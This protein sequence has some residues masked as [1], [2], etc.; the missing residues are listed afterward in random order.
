[1][2]FFKLTR[3]AS[4]ISFDGATVRYIK[5]VQQAGKIVIARFIEDASPNLSTFVSQHNL[6]NEI[7]SM[8][9]PEEESFFKFLEKDDGVNE[10][11]ETLLSEH[12]PKG[13]DAETVSMECLPLDK[14][15][16]LLLHFDHNEATDKLKQVSH[17][18][19][20][21]P[22]RIGGGICEMGIAL[23]NFIEKDYTGTVLLMEPKLCH[24]IIF[25]QGAFSDCETLHAGQIHFQEN[26]IYF[27]NEVSRF[28]IYYWET[29]QIK[30]GFNDIHL[31]ESN[32]SLEEFFKTQG[33]SI[34]SLNTPLT[35]SNS[36][37]YALAYNSLTL[38]MAAIN[39]NSVMEPRLK[40][41]LLFQKAEAILLRLVFPI[42][43]LSLVLFLFI[44]LSL[45]GVKHLGEKR[46][47]L[48]G[49]EIEQTLALRE[50]NKSLLETI[51]EA[52]TLVQGRN[53]E[54][55][56]FQILSRAMPTDVWLTSMQYDRETGQ[57][58][59]LGGVS[60][61]ETAIQ[62]LYTN[63]EKDGHFKNV[64][65]LFTERMDKAEIARKSSRS[66]GQSI[67][68]FSIEMDAP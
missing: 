36:Q 67:V 20:L 45:Y 30:S 2:R 39:H 43:G 51:H 23:Q 56:I 65:L 47:K 26:P 32:P 33:Y 53:L 59:V 7:V 41:G 10:S 9:A 48:K 4:A 22:D 16:G 42:V 21:I 8:S 31:L 25:S 66:L 60:G 63:L 40:N 29:K 34:S 64:R 46:L 52:R 38:G 49:G 54:S 27:L 18:S 44:M 1:M 17:N 55:G 35:N 68:R 58:I 11:S 13:V 12:L 15:K 24:A 3:Q 62:T 28:L 50:E 5:L 61:K 14:S 57:K 6:Y 19:K 37:V